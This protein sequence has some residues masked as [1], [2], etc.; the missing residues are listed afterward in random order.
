MFENADWNL[1][2]I[3]LGALFGLLLV[4][5]ESYQAYQKY[6]VPKREKE[7]ERRGET[8][9]ERKYTRRRAARRIL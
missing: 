2:F 7:K 1:I 9:K 8:E 6:V 5:V 3:G 4:I